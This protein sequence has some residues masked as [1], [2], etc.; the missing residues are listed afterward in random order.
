MPYLPVP[1]LKAKYIARDRSACL[2]HQKVN[3]CIPNV[4]QIACRRKKKPQRNRSS[5]RNFL[6]SIGPEFLYFLFYKSSRPNFLEIEKKKKRFFSILFF[7]FPPTGASTVLEFSY[8]SSFV[9]SIAARLIKLPPA[10]APGEI[11]PF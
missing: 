6:K 3:L 4:G 10:T 8:V 5:Q 7:Y 2:D 11:L 9:F 1:M